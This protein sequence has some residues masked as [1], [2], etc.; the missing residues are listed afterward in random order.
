MNMLRVQNSY[1]ILELN[2]K[3]K[4]NAYGNSVHETEVSID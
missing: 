1:G 4:S 2:Q 3:K